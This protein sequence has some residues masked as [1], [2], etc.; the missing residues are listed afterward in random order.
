M[1]FDKKY[2]EKGRG[3]D[4]NGGGRRPGTGWVEGSE[5]AKIK[6]DQNRVVGSDQSIREKSGQQNIRDR[7]G[8]SKRVIRGSERSGNESWGSSN[9]GARDRGASDW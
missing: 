1:L 8:G 4:L 6:F 9:W 5:Q 7:V 3:E 2:E